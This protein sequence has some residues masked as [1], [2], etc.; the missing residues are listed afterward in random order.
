MSALR[1]MPALCRSLH[2]VGKV[3]LRRAAVAKASSCKEAVHSRCACQWR[4]LAE[5]KHTLTASVACP[6]QWGSHDRANRGLR[7]ACMPHGV[8]RMAGQDAVC[9]L[10]GLLLLHAE[11][12]GHGHFGSPHALCRR[13]QSCGLLS[14][15]AS[16]AAS[17]PHTVRGASAAKP[18]NNH[19]HASALS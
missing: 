4:R 5:H 17:S 8:S 2:T 16:Q 7:A 12:H 11:R 1:I 19:A 14:M 10:Q 13:K 6:E 9:I 15:Q 18:L 3:M